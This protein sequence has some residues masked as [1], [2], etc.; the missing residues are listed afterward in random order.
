MANLVPNIQAFAE[1]S[2]SGAAVFELI[3]RES[4][5]NIF[6]EDGEMPSKLNGDI[7]FRNVHFTYPSRQEAKVRFL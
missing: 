5:I 1:A 3:K 2:G 7:E 4:K 6:R